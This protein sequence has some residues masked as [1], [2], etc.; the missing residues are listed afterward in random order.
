MMSKI[1]HLNFVDHFPAVSPRVFRIC[2]FSL[3]KTSAGSQAPLPQAASRTRHSCFAELRLSPE[4]PIY[5]HSR[6]DRTT[7]GF[8]LNLFIYFNHPR[9]GNIKSICMCIYIYQTS[10]FGQDACFMLKTTLT[11][12]LISIS[13]CCCLSL[14][15]W[16]SI[17]RNGMV[18]HEK[19]I[20]NLRIIHMVRKNL[21][22][23]MLV[24]G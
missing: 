5:F 20:K 12:L 22:S 18:D 23:P 13:F 6:V 17:Q 15:C 24:G 16:R 11:L 4:A 7:N 2:Y 19:Q 3:A 9:N 14:L 10:F 21:G 8:S 1:K